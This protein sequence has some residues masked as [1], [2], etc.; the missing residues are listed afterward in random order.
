MISQRAA[1]QQHEALAQ[2]L[3]RAYTAI[4]QSKRLLMARS[5]RR[6]SHLVGEPLGRSLMEVE[7]LEREIER[8]G[9]L[10]DECALHCSP[11][12]PQYWITAY[13]RLVGLSDELIG[14]ME[15]SLPRMSESTRREVLGA[16][17]PLLKEGR[18]DFLS[19]LR[20]RQI[21]LMRSHRDP[22]RD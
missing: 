16:D 10:R 6:A 20:S 4:L 14:T 7:R 8:F 11:S 1:N 5:T 2:T 12:E 22:H 13:S 15:A 19:H 9:L 3:L 18:N 17:L 21:A